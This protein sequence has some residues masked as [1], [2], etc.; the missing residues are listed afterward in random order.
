[1]SHEWHTIK[2]R[3]PMNLINEFM[4]FAYET[5]SSGICTVSAVRLSGKVFS[6][7]DEAL[8]YVTSSSY[9]KDAAYMAA[10][11]TKKLSKAYQN[12]YDNFLVKYKEYIAFKDNLTIAYGRSASKTTCPNCGSSINL[13]YGKRFKAC[14]VCGSNKIISDSNWKMLDTKRRMCVKAAENL[15]KEAEKNDV[16]FMC[17]IEWHC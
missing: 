8:N 10:Y 7:E 5:D 4:G 2:G 13:K 11:T 6:T 3:N 16:T 1:M 12:A 17:G 14:P 9:Y 15:S